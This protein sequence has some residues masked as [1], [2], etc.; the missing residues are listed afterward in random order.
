MDKLHYIKPAVRAFRAYSLSPHRASVKLNQN[1]NPWDA[2][3]RIKEEVL[4][5]FAAR[6]W[7]GIPISCLPSL[8]E[9]LAEFAQWKPDGIIAGNGSN[10]L[11]QAL[12]MVTI[13]SGKKVLI[14]E[15]TFALYKQV[16]TVLGGEV[17]SVLLTNS[18]QYDTAALQRIVEEKRPDVVIICS[19]NNPTRLRDRR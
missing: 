1:E 14:S 15:P 2:P 18:L 8:H 5:R 7:S 11:I 4:R 10:E 12:L 3:L 9:R 16:A 6:K 19:P 13:A 17:E